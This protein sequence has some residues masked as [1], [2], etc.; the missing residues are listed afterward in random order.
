MVAN[1]WET[2]TLEQVQE[3]YI[4]SGRSAMSAAATLGIS[5]ST[6][7]RVMKR[8]GL[9]AQGRQSAHP[10]LRDKEWLRDQYEVQKK[11]C[12]QIAD[13]IG[14]T[15][16]TVHS[17]LKWL[18]VDLRKSKEGLSIRYPNGRFGENASNWKGGRKKLGAGGHIMLHKPE[19]PNST[20]DGYVM[21]HR[22]V[23]EEKIGRLLKKTEIVHHI[24]GNKS[25]N[26]PE[27]LML[28]AN[29][30]EHKQAHADAV[31]EVDLLK[32]ENEMLK[33]LLEN[34]GIGGA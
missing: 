6:F 26:R 25:D 20:K 14:A 7:R 3:V 1:V 19:H 18:N 17:A 32:K 22:L 10:E 8:F 5:Y 16:G 21:E 33:R 31:Q 2:I 27:N 24:N 11:S 23:M 12:R 34:T 30:A 9:K 28:F 4:N 29:H 13:E 15:R